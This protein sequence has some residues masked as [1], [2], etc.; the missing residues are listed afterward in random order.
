MNLYI[1]Y[2]APRTRGSSGSRPSWNKCSAYSNSRV[3][4]EGERATGQAGKSRNGAG[5]WRLV[6]VKAKKHSGE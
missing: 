6:K 2:R 4:I 3:K 1:L 5:A